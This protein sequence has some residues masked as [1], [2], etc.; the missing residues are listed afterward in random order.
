VNITDYRRISLL[1]LAL[2]VLSFGTVSRAATTN[3][4]IQ[5]FSFSPPSVDIKVNDSV[6]WTWASGFHSTTSSDSLW[7]SG[8]HFPPASFTNVF[9]SAGDFPYFCSVHPFMTAAVK[10]TGGANLP[11]SV[12]LTNPINATVFAAPWIAN[13]GADA[14]DPDGSVTN[15]QFFNGSTSLGNA[16]SAPFKLSVTNLPAGNYNLR[17]VASDNAGLTTTS[18]VVSVSAV[19]PVPILLS[20]PE[21]V[22]GSQFKFSYTASPGLRYLV[23]TAQTLP[24]FSSLA[25]N[26]AATSSVTVTDAVATG[27]QQFYR[28]S[29]LPNPD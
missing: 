9:S 1:A 4:T 6:I 16:P 7:D 2:G 26:V 23:E 8:A 25:T 10:V 12:S 5:D 18:A 15:V 13:L 21:S 14:T 19:N 28:V 27:S 3:V 24:D 22:A 11:P 29:R 17:A 20:D